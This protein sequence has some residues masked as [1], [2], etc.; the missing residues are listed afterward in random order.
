M[1]F[2]AILTTNLNIHIAIEK[3]EKCLYD[4][5]STFDQGHIIHYNV[6]KFYNG[7]SLKHNLTLKFSDNRKMVE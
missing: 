4:K 2:T 5:V 7:T 1:L 3:G 6:T